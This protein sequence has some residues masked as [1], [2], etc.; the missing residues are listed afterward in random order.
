MTAAD[1]ELA[2]NHRDVVDAMKV[3]GAA[4]EEA[5]T[6]N[7]AFTELMFLLA[8]AARAVG[9]DLKDAAIRNAIVFGANLATMGSERLI[10]SLAAIERVAVEMGDSR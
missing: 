7:S 3:L 1:E 4:L 9:V 2:Q 10:L 6:D 5:N 8:T